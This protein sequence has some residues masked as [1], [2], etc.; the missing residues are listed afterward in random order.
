MPDRFETEISSNQTAEHV[1]TETAE[2]YTDKSRLEVRLRG[3]FVTDCKLTSPSTGQRI[4]VLH[5][6]PELDVAKLTASHVM[7]P[8]SK[9]E[10]V[11]GQ[12]G[13]PRWADYHV[14]EASSN[15]PDS[16][17]IGL[18]A[19]RSD[20]GLGLSKIFDITENALTTRTTVT[21]YE[22]SAAR[23]SLGEHLYFNL[24]D[25]NTE[26]L[27]VNGE[28][29]DE[30]L[31]DGSEASIMQGNAMPYTDFDGEVAIKFPAGH[32]IRLTCKTDDPSQAN[33]LILTVWHR[34]GNDSICF[35]PMLGFSGETGNE[36]LH[37][38]PQ[39]SQSL[40]TKIEVL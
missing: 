3:C 36:G 27:T 12:H 28:T 33:K 9:S 17:R 31:G 19:K 34:P 35:E 20:L 26:G 38:E 2:I 14:F 23:T 5:S 30:L 32:T 24:P 1:P 37:I 11:G 16:K 6:D 22:T 18:Q 29:L 25:E 10:G 15:G 40:M 39:S 21:N 8:V 13:Y 4:I 7:M